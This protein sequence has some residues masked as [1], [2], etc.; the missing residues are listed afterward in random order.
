MKQDE[1]AELIPIPDGDLLR[2]SAM[3]LE[4]R[5]QWYEARLEERLEEA[6]PRHQYPTSIEEAFGTPLATDEPVSKEN[7]AQ[8]APAVETWP[9]WRK[10][11]IT[12]AMRVLGPFVVAT[13]EGPLSCQDG[14]LAID[15][16]GYPYPIANDEFRQIYAAAEVETTEP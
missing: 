13:S 4:D 3:S 15:A 14:W 10:T 2:V 9:T 5:V 16:R 8:M 6:R 11:S 12:S 1:L 7:L